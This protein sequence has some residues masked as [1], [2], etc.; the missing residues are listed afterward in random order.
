[1][2]LLFSLSL[3]SLSSNHETIKEI[4]VVFQALDR[5]LK[6]LRV[7]GRV[8]EL[9]PRVATNGLRQDRPGLLLTPK[10]SFFFHDFFAGEG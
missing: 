4:A 8:N 7:N 3:G 6:L 2:L 1:M 9:V 10:L 5:E